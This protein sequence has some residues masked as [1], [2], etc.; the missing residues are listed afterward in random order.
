M[1]PLT[2][3]TRFARWRL[4]FV[5]LACFLPSAALF[6][7]SPPPQP[8]RRIIKPS[9]ST[10]VSSSEAGA[11]FQHHIPCHTFSRRFVV[12]RIFGQKRK[13]PICTHLAATN[14]PAVNET[15]SASSS[16]LLRD[17]QHE[18]LKSDKNHYANDDWEAMDDETLLRQVTKTQLLD[19]CQQC[20]INVT[21]STSTSARRKTTTKVDLL[22]LLR[23]HA[24]RVIQ[25]E[26]QR[27][28]QR[29]VMVEQGVSDTESKERYEIIPGDDFGEESDDDE[30]FVFY[31]IDQLPRTAKM[32]P[33]NASTA[34]SHTPA[35]SSTP[36]TDRTQ[37]AN[38]KAPPKPPSRLS[39]AAVT[40]P[41]PPPP[42]RSKNGEEVICERTVMVYSTKDENDLTG[43][44]AAQPGQAG[45][46]VDSLLSS[47]SSSSLS[48]DIPSSELF[49]GKATSAETEQ[50]TEKVTELV[51]TLLAMTGLPAFTGEMVSPRKTRKDA[52]SRNHQTTH[53]GFDPSKVPTELLSSSSQAL[54]TGRG[55]VLRDVLRQFE[56]QAIGQDGM[57]GDNTE[58]GGGH[59]RQVS[60]VRAFLEGYRRAE[61][62][63]I[64]RE[65]TS[66]L[67]DR[68]V[69]EGVQG[70]DL[71][72]ASM[73]RASDD[74]NDYGGGELNDS[75]LDYLNDAIRQQEKKVK[76]QMMSSAASSQASAERE[77]VVEESFIND[78]V[79]NLWNITM[80][81]G[82]VVE[83]L[84]PNDPKVLRVL[85]EELELESA[86]E[87]QQAA[88][89]FPSNPPEQI[90][91]LLELLR[92]RIKAEAAFS[93]DEKGRNLRLLAYCLH[94]ATDAEREQLLL[95]DLRSSID[96]L[97][98]FIELVKSSIEYGESTSYQL[99]PTKKNALNVRQLRG[100]LALSE[101]LREQQ[102][103]RLSGAR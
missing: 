39:Q 72:M 9:Y 97:D 33:G 99:Q 42:I 57:A 96:R 74:T 44:A 21:M 84:D 40:A 26:R 45:I 88:S 52:A 46:A 94:L 43:I 54:R 8:H 36:T 67:L 69:S 51:E 85:H 91:L 38:A 92:E 17:Q 16:N 103:W 83:S 71:A 49:S 41:L 10:S 61:V 37:T 68:L 20:Q 79:E 70:L 66:V 28:E 81:D 90:L 47:S 93:L 89:D 7:L 35:S 98:S 95:K 78:P 77:N 32:Q 80:E 24:R 86:M 64:A 19:L 55:E 14:T 1:P 18:A 3:F 53:P 22:Q 73:L 59:Y 48:S 13:W 12:R 58:K 65:T 2:K 31:S 102:A 5:W 23:Q 27:L 50:A 15:T 63:R 82:N 60:K 76:Q 30:P 29:I 25:E 6:S 101:D 62:R 87:K 4:P 100:I 75:L 11:F 56:I 34:G